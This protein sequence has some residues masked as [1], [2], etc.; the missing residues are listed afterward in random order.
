MYFGPFLCKQEGIEGE[1]REK[2]RAVKGS[3]V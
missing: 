2:E 3:Q 1:E